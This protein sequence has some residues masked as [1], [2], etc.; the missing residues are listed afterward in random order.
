MRNVHACVRACVCTCISVFV[1]CL[2]ASSFFTPLVAGRCIPT[3][4]DLD[5][6]IDEVL[7]LDGNDTID[8]SLNDTVDL[9]LDTITL[10]DIRDGTL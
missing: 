10:G 8:P 2:I 9:S 1:L 5:S 6:I 4:F 7:Y 3:I